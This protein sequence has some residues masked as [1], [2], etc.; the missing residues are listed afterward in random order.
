MEIC[1]FKVIFPKVTH[2]H[3][4]TSWSRLAFLCVSTSARGS[5]LSR[6]VHKVFPNLLPIVMGKM[7]R[8]FLGYPN[9]RTKSR[10]CS[11]SW[12]NDP[13]S[14]KE[15]WT[16]RNDCITQRER[17]SQLHFNKN[18]RL[19]IEP[20]GTETCWLVVWTC[21]DDISQTPHEIHS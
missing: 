4:R 14:T 1:P 3:R 13:H 21:L 17:S 15:Y 5:W 16:E 2:P 20:Y 8:A 18:N 19:V 7:R 12:L 6:M 11:R 9:L 10:P